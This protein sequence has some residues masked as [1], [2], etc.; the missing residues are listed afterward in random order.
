V[1]DVLGLWTA[2]RDGSGDCE[3]DTNAE[4]DCVVPGDCVDVPRAV[5]EKEPRE[6]EVV[7]WDT[8]LVL[9]VL[10]LGAGVTDASEVTVDPCDCVDVP[11]EDSDTLLEGDNDPRLLAVVD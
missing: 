9:D 2:V 4:D 1:L 5:D 3:A 7:D 8:E 10:E 11:T 6:L